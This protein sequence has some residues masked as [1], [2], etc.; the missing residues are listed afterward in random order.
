MLRRW[1]SPSLSR[2][3]AGLHLNADAI[4]VDRLCL[5][6]SKARLIVNRLT[7]PE[8][9]SLIAEAGLVLNTD[10]EAGVVRGCG[11]GRSLMSVGTSR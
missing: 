2:D 4:L 1:G 10:T 3:V 11:T 5:D 6:P 7:K 8:M 9:L